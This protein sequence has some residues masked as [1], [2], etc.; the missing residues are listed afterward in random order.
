[1]KLP[2]DHECNHEC[3]YD[4]DNHCELRRRLQERAKAKAQF[5]GDQAWAKARDMLPILHKVKEKLDS[6]ASIVPEDI[7]VIQ[8]ALSIVLGEI[9]LRKAQSLIDGQTNL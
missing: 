3:D 6:G 9:Y 5:Q 1:M 7:V 4:D 2:K 8:S